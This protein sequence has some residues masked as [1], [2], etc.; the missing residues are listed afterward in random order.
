MTGRIEYVPNNLIN[1]EKWDNWVRRASNRR[2]YAMSFL[3]DIF[4]PGWGALI[5]DDGHAFMPVTWKRKFGVSYVYQPIFV[6]QLGCFFL[7]NSYS[8]SLPY[9]IE[10]LSAS[11]RFIDISMNEANYY[12]NDL[13]YLSKMSNYLLKLDKSYDLIIRQYNTNTRRNIIKAERLGLELL[14]HYTPSEI[15]RLFTQ[16][17]GRLYPN[18]RKKN[19]TRLQ[20]FIDKGLADGFIQIKAARA[21]NGQ[22]IAAACFLKEFDRY[23]FYF[24]ANTE[25]GRNQGALF[26]LI[27]SFIKQNSESFMILDFNGSMNK[28]IARFY[29]GFGAEQTFY[30]RLKINRLGFPINLIKR[31]F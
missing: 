1:K 17:K 22:V 30:H 11:F 5:M 8:E 19:Y 13:I 14:P 25:E 16:N 23:V 31:L 6:Q 29:R 20:F 7:D 27:N 4:S 21:L 3:L 9:F 28:N 26:F 24:S 10:K 2:I 12:Q 18:I 15:I